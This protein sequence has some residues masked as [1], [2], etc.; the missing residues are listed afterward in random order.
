M[1][2]VCVRVLRTYW[3]TKR[4]TY[5]SNVSINRDKYEKKGV[6]LNYAHK[7]TKKKT[8]SLFELFDKIYLQMFLQSRFTIIFWLVNIDSYQ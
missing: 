6:H 5:Y 3:Y 7:R 8:F 4:Q 2:S 1:C